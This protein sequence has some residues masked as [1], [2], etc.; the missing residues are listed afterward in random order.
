MLL[1]LPLR[2][3]GVDGKDQRD[4]ERVVPKALFLI[5]PC[6]SSR[7]WSCPG[8][9]P[10]PRTQEC[11]CPSLL[12]SSPRPARCGACCRL[13]ERA[14][15]L[16]PIS[17]ALQRARAAA[18]R[19]AATA[20]RALVP[21]LERHE[22]GAAGLRAERPP[23]AQPRIASMPTALPRRPKQARAMLTPFMLL[24]LSRRRLCASQIH[25]TT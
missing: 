23:S 6:E 10:R 24:T 19:R 11:P 20:A 21:R 5:E 18:A 16:R 13:R 9:H 12:A 3:R 1:P 2:R 25:K 14:R 4:L 15:P 7:R 8:P 22:S 17:Q